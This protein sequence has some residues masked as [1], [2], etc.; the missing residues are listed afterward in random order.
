MNDNHV[1]VIAEAGVNHNGSLEIAKKLV[2]AAKDAGADV[3]KF[4]TAN[5]KASIT[6]HAQTADYQNRN[7]GDTNQLAMVEKLELPFS[8]YIKIKDYC[9]SKDIVFGTTF[10]DEEGAKFSLENLELTFCKVASGEVTNLPLLELMSRTQLPVLLS[11]GMC[12]LEE[13]GRAIK[14]LKNSGSKN[15]TVLHCTTEYPAPFNEVNLRS[16]VEMGRY[17]D[18]PFGY[19]DHTKGIE[20]PI[21]AVALGAQVIE[22]H[23]TLDNNMEGPDHKASLEP[24]EF[25]EM[26]S[27]IRNIEKA[28][29]SKE[30]QP[31]A[32][33]INNLKIARKSI[34]AKRAIKAGEIFNEENLT[35]KR[36]GA[37]ISPMQ[38]YEVI[39]KIAKRDFQE[40]ELIEL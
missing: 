36:P 39:G 18:L 37:G 13:V 2:D 9:K 11:T 16:M 10:F 30:K 6:T 4:Q 15:I 17:F 40:D 21:A 22:K 32:S 8:D 31:S 38:W 29:G 7:T 14:V 20:V 3:I 35:T 33:E 34:V 19:S 12:T 27:A 24:D 1:M 23:L 26:V 25:A 28:L 5:A